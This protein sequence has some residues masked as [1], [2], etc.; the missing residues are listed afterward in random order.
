V[1]LF[2]VVKKAGSEANGKEG[3]HLVFRSQ[4]CKNG[5]PPDEDVVANADSKIGTTK[6]MLKHELGEQCDDGT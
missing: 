3:N 2:V 4:I 6:K 1:A 5:G